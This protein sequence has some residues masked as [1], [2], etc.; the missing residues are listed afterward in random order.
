MY[1][2]AKS[3]CKLFAPCQYHIIVRHAYENANV[4]VKRKNNFIRLENT[5]LINKAVYLDVIWDKKERSE[6]MGISSEAV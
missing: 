4:E 3:M 6:G 5:M 1:I 2:L